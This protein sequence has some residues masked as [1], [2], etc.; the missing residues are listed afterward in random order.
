MD[1]DLVGWTPEIALGDLKGFRE[2]KSDSTWPL[3]ILISPEKPLTFDM[4]S[5]QRH[6]Q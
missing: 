6:I 4:S 1:G 2:G 5:V 3:L